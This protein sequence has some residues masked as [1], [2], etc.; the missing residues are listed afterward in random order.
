V[1]EFLKELNNEGNTVILITHDLSIASEAKRIIKI[2]DGKIISDEV[3]DW[4]GKSD[5]RKAII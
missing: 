3:I 4:R 1:L 5:E 2:Q